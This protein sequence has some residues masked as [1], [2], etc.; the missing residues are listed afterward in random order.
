MN[1]NIVLFGDSLL[2]NYH[3]LDD[4]EKDLKHALETMGYSVDNYS[5]ENCGITNVFTGVIVTENH[6]LNRKYPYQLTSGKLYPVD[7]LIDNYQSKSVFPSFHRFDFTGDTDKKQCDLIVL[8]I[9]GTDFKTSS[10]K[11]LLGCD[12]FIS[13]VLTE[14]FT[15]NYA[16]LI[17]LLKRFCNK[18][19]IVS[20]YIPFLGQGSTYGPFSGLSQNIITKW[21]QFIYDIAKNFDVAVLDLSKTTDPLNRSHY[22]TNDT[23]PSTILSDCMA[24]CISHIEHNY[25]GYKIFYCPNC[26]PLS[27]S[28]SLS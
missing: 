15:K 22:G 28:S 10:Y 14:D 1:K 21:R 18:I 6:I 20:P 23:Y 3:S 7:L 9:G 11:L 25:T 19:I 12:Y 13:S 2:D 26:D 4:Q 24:H 5:A 8:S 17:T 27:I 16:K